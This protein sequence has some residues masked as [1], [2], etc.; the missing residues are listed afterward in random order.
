MIWESAVVSVCECFSSMR[1][2]V[3]RVWKKSNRILS[4]EIHNNLFFG[5]YYLVNLSTN[6]MNV[7]TC[8]SSQVLKWRWICKIF[9]WW[10]NLNLHVILYDIGLDWIDVLSPENII[11]NL[12]NY[13]VPKSIGW[14][15]FS[16]RTLFVRA[17]EF[18][19]LIKVF[20]RVSFTECESNVFALYLF[21]FL[22]NCMTYADTHLDLCLFS[23][24]NILDLSSVQF[25]N[26]IPS[27]ISTIN[28]HEILSRPHRMNAFNCFTANCIGFF[29]TPFFLLWNKKE[30]QLNLVKATHSF[31]YVCSIHL[32]C[33]CCCCLT[34]TSKHLTIKYDNN[35]LFSI[36]MRV[37]L[38]WPTFARVSELSLDHLYSVHK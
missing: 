37:F 1:S 2:V 4:Y 33:C 35:W 7:Q 24:K 8:Q 13:F 16:I 5:C 17:H 22:C 26:K 21:P 36:W 32:F 18:H 9:Q 20:Q 6:G 19:L 15:F 25:S 10:I 3:Y 38:L 23:F 11:R 27:I 28:V 34:L 29:F 30:D 31:V 14:F 12:F